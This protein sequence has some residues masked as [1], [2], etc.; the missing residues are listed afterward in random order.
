[1][2]NKF[3]EDGRN[4]PSTKEVRLLIDS[5]VEEWKQ[6]KIKGDVRI[7]PLFYLFVHYADVNWIEEQIENRG[8]VA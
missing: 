5:F 8:I 3:T 1:M 2:E 6:D 4:F 7:S